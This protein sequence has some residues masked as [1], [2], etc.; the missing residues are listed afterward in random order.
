MLI[1][2]RGSNFTAIA[3]VMAAQAW[4]ADIVAV[5]SNKADAAG[6]E[7]ARERG[8]ATAALSHKDFADRA[9]FDAA[10]MALIDGYQPDL[11]ILAGFMRILTDAFVDH[12]AGRLINIHPSLLPSFPGLKTHEQALDAGVRLHG[13]TVHFVTPTLD[14]GPVLIQ[15]AVPVK[16]GDDPA[17]LAARVLRVEHQI[18]PLAVRWLIDGQARLV[19]GKVLLEPGLQP[20]VFDSVG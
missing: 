4:S 18:Y 12:Y 6:L 20:W 15:G 14:H 16:A 5:I 11:V 3:D 1:S 10:M 7:H 8:F 13:A 19:D 9:G 2:G 17:T